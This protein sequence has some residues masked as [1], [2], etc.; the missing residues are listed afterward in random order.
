MARFRGTVRGDSL[1]SNTCRLAEKRL[2]TNCNGQDIGVRVVAEVFD[3]KERFTIIQTG[4]NNNERSKFI[5]R[6]R[7]GK[8]ELTSTSLKRKKKLTK[9]AD[10]DKIP[11][12]LEDHKNENQST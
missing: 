12:S 5:G 10:Y 7:D 2:I 11:K 4:G 3:G 9:K 6:I 8:L 1:K